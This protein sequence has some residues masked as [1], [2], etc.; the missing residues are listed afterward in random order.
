MALRHQLRLWR[1]ST[2]IRST[3]SPRDFS[4]VIQHIH[5]LLLPSACLCR[6]IQTF[7]WNDVLC[8]G[9]S[10]VLFNFGHPEDRA[11]FLYEADAADDQ[12]V[13]NLA[14]EQIFTNVKASYGRGMEFLVHTSIFI[15]RKDRVRRNMVDMCNCIGHAVCCF[16]FM[17]HMSTSYCAEIS[18]CSACNCFHTIVIFLLFAWRLLD[19]WHA[20]Q[21]RTKKSSDQRTERPTLRIEVPYSRGASPFKNAST[22]VGG[23]LAS[24]R[25][26]VWRFFLRD[27]MLTVR[28]L[29]KRYI[30]GLAWRVVHRTPSKLWCVWLR[31]L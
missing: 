19:Y 27:R 25:S 8:K 14:V 28:R 20:C 17:F 29:L 7:T 5:I 16:N 2:K 9:F 10:T 18:L 6:Q 15:S 12:G 1:T 3:A 13:L 24:L 4:K 11:R 26:C 30:S 31:S 22:S 23:T 21:F